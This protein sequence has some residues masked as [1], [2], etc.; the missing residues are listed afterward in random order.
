LGGGGNSLDETLLEP[1][2]ELYDSSYKE[3]NN[4]Q[5]F[6][7][8]NFD[9]YSDDMYEAVGGFESIDGSES[10]KIYSGDVPS[11]SPSPSG[12]VVPDMS[13]MLTPDSAGKE[14]Q[15]QTQTQNIENITNYIMN[16]ATSMISNPYIK[17]I[18]IP[19]SIGNA[20]SAGNSKAHVDE[21]FDDYSKEDEFFEE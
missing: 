9:G 19:S 7:D 2:T 15:T 21:N 3:L 12:H 11:S 16:P 4:Y 18:D 17:V 13:Y 14:T 20:S 6:D 1:N 10:I 5:N 8:K